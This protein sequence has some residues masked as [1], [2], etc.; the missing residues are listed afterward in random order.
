M[1]QVQNHYKA[2]VLFEVSFDTHGNNYL[3][4]YGKHVN[5][6]FCSIPNWKV[7]CE[8]AEPSDTFY[9]RSR[10]SEALIPV[11]AAQG[12]AEMIKVVAEA[13]NVE[14]A[15]QTVERVVLNELIENLYFSI[16]EDERKMF[17]IVSKERLARAYAIAKQLYEYDLVDK[18][19]VEAFV[20]KVT[21]AT[22]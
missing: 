2:T 10:L 12:I 21:G 22:E 18:D 16:S 14:E 1:G 8:M 11:G 20:A 17:E 3:V 19:E 15:P 9:N 4:I 5:G 7:S 6:Y 13:W